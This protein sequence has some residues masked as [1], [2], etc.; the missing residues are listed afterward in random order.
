MLDVYAVMNSDLGLGVPSSEENIV[1]NLVKNGI[2]TARMGQK[3]KRMRG[4]RNILVHRYGGV[5]DSAFETITEGL[6]DFRHFEKMV[7]K[8]LSK[9]GK[10]RFSRG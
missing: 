9:H 10:S 4:F 2:I 1:D 8:I 7:K 5:D 3:I 6:G